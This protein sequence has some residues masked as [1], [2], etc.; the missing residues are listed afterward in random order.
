M[1]KLMSI[2]RNIKHL[3]INIIF[4]LLKK[5]IRLNSPQIIDDIATIK[6]IKDEHLS[7][8]RFGDGELRWM[9]GIDNDSFQD[10]NSDLSARLKEIIN[11][12]VSGHIVCLPDVFT[13]QRKYTTFNSLAWKK[14]IIKNWKLWFPYINKNKV[15]Y[16]SNFTRPYIDRKHKEKSGELFNQ[17]KEIW[18]NKNIL[19]VEG[20]KTRFGVD[21]DLISNANKIGRI[22][23]PAVNAFD[24]YSEIIE[25]VKKNASDYDLILLALGPTA[26][27]MAY[28]LSL[29]GI[30]AIDIGQVDIEY[31]W[32]LRG[33]TKRIPIKNKYVNEVKEGRKIDSKELKN[34][35]YQ[36]EILTIVS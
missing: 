8:S 15:F 24:S 33:A 12:D 35:T 7:V 30:Q 2:M 21:N 1:D 3:K 28:D 31:E 6:K 29:F 36:R 23:G 14:L 25:A 22:L 17:I 20:Q 32:Y 11:S 10:N 34:K 26:T 19:I 18:L 13:E 5:N 9:T 27:V 16:D 4:L